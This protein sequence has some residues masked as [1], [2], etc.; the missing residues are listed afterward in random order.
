M[1][2][3]KTE[4]LRQALRAEFNTS[5]PLRGLTF[6]QKRVDIEFLAHILTEYKDGFDEDGNGHISVW[7]HRLQSL[8]AVYED[9]SLE[10]SKHVDYRVF[11]SYDNPWT[12]EYSSHEIMGENNDEDLLPVAHFFTTKKSVK[13]LILMETIACL[14][15]GKRQ[16]DSIAIT[17]LEPQS[18]TETIAEK[19]MEIFWDYGEIHP[20]DLDTLQ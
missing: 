2:F 15:H 10:K 17:V 9:G 5:I 8:Y 4:G 7:K 14:N 18:D 20:D 11:G 12:G 19:L 6:K 13:H 16:I 3:C 1:I